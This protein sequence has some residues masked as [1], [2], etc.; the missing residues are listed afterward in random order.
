MPTVSGLERPPRPPDRPP[1]SGL[2]VDSEEET[3][4]LGEVAR[5]DFLGPF[6]LEF[7]DR[8]SDHVNRGLAAFGED[9]ALGAQVV[10]VGLPLEVVEAF[11]LSEQVVEGL[12][13]HPEPNGQ[14]GGPCALRSG[15]LEDVEVGSVEVCEALLMQPIQHAS[16]HRLPGH[17][18]ER[19]DQRRPERLA[20]GRFR[21][22]T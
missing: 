20:R 3:P 11:E 7:A 21:K 19:A 15:I 6:G 18:Q 14:L 22:G 13:A 4:E 12:L 1:S 17:A 10:G 2:L 5:A 16:L 9:N 8:L